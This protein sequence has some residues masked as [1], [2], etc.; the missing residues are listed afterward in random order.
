VKISRIILVLS[1]LIVFVMVFTSC[2]NGQSKTTT[3]PTT[4]KALPVTTTPGQT[5]ATSL[6]VTQPST[7][8]SAP[9]TTP[10]SPVTTS[11]GTPTTTSSAIPGTTTPVTTT[12]VVTT[13]QPTIE[14]T[15][16]VDGLDEALG[17]ITGYG[18]VSYD[19]VT[20]GAGESF[21]TSFWIKGG[22]MRSE[23][24]AEGEQMIMLLDNEAR[25]LY[26]Y[27]PDQNMAM[28]M[29]YEPSDSVVDETLQITQYEP[30][31]TGTETLD[32]KVCLVVEYLSGGS[33]VKT[34]IWKEKGFPLKVETVTT[35]GKMVV[36]Y[37]NISFDNIPD[38]M[39][40]IPAGVEVME[41]PVPGG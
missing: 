41:F 35:E 25:T 11:T 1:L 37:K 40:E 30:V 38:D 36:E 4:T 24:M 16:T 34:W 8:S 29:A 7:T 27:M 15:E 26:M 9:A 6:P 3:T 33:Q 23:M 21:T 32:G 5:Q 13:S 28:K 31:V 14:P 10:V 17:N 18:S 2:G 39:F 19:M 12:P 20:T 22:K